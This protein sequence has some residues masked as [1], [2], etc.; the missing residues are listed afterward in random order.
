MSQNKASIRLQ[1]VI[2]IALLS[3]IV[4]ALLSRTAQASPF[5][6]II[7]GEITSISIDSELYVIDEESD[8]EIEVFIQFEMTNTGGNVKDFRAH[9]EIINPLGETVYDS[10][11]EDEDRQITRKAGRSGIVGFRW[12]P[13]NESE[14]GIYT[15]IAKLQDW[16]KRSI[17][18]DDRDAEAGLTFEIRGVPKLFISPDTLSLGRF[19]PTET[20]F[21]NIA[22]RN[23][24]RSVLTWSVTHWPS[25]WVEIIEPAPN[26]VIT[27]PGRIRIALKK[28][29]PL[30]ELRGN[31]VIESNAS[32]EDARVPITASVD[33]E[34]NGEITR[35]HVVEPLYRQGEQISVDLTARNTGEL[36]LDYIAEITVLDPDRRVVY[37]SFLEVTSKKLPLEPDEMG[38][39]TL[40]WRLPEDAL[41]GNYQV[42]AELRY[43]YNRQTLFDRLPEVD[44]ERFRVAERPIMS[45]E[46]Q[47]W[48]FGRVTEGE[49][50]FNEF[51]LQN[52][53]GF[54][55]LNWEVV[56]LPDWIV[57]AGSNKG[58]DSSII[59]L[60]TSPSAPVGEYVGT[61]RVVSNGGNITLNLSAVVT[62]SKVATPTQT[63]VPSTSTPVPDKATPV[64]TE[65]TI[66]PTPEQQDQATPS[67]TATATPL[68]AEPT[69][70]PKPN[71]PEA[72]LTQEA[73][74]APLNAPSPEP[75]I[76]S[77]PVDAKPE[78]S[79]ATVIAPLEDTS[80][81]ET[82]SGGACGVA[83]GQLSLTTST[84]NALLMLLPIGLIGGVKFSRR[85]R[86]NR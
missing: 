75:A 44:M 18:Y 66:T 22:V 64:V 69:V 26:E 50:A 83:V 82:P 35:L 6:Q 21:R 74:A 56:D 70:T 62:S 52:T 3:I 37:S 14:E 10:E 80:P 23:T 73:T 79:V 1:K 45:I 30:R 86:S 31:L 58:Q 65:S 72:E 67:P 27:G 49:I 61:V 34:V 51:D 7:S 57:L 78:P 13:P 33:G 60:E 32:E 15:V 81:T 48:D 76:P 11:R 47:T 68:P 28:S 59:R 29:A 20:P 71:T 17:V 12:V 42:T 41:I 53:S 24:G 16:R 2:A 25:E 77:A 9:V 39:T 84:V 5:R 46:P 54:G 43:W 63:S 40:T 55:I 38:T 19:K 36:A 4:M 85:K 8:E